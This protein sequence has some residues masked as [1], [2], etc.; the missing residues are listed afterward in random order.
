MSF[1]DADSLQL[2]KREQSFGALITDFAWLPDESGILTFGNQ[3][4]TAIH[5]LTSAPE[6]V[7]LAPEINSDLNENLD[8]RGVALR[9]DTVAI[10]TRGGVYLARLR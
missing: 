1:W 2:I 4:G 6:R 5:S 3:A 10:G 8:V 9:D 7:L